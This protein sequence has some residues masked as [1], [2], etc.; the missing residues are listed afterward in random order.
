MTKS[1]DYILLDRSGSMASKWDETISSLNAYV[2]ELSKK[3]AKSTVTVAVFD[4]HN[5]M[6]FD[7]IRDSV[8]IKKWNK[9]TTDEV[10]PRGTT[11]LLDAVSRIIS[12][13]EQKNSKKTVIVVITD[14]QENASREVTKEDVQKAVKRCEDKKWEV[15][16]LGADFEAFGNAKMSG[17]GFDK[18]MTMTGSNY[19]D[20]MRNLAGKS[21][22]YGLTGQM[23]S[24]SDADRAEASKK[25]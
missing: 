14:G 20:T 6:Q 1:N 12:I 24:F 7:V 17:V 4:D 5:R 25:K 10:T 23:M 13:A 3:G 19:E 9:I 15:I 8:D 18:T 16:F 22:S 21:A 11:P 2:D